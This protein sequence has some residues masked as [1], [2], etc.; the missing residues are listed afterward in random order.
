MEQSREVYETATNQLGSFLEL[1]SNR[2]TLPKSGTPETTGGV[3]DRRAETGGVLAE[4]N[5]ML[6]DS[7]RWVI[8]RILKSFVLN[9]RN[10]FLI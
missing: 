5:K 6:L 8:L 9:H 10:Y 4:R 1:V 2:L 3:G 7:D